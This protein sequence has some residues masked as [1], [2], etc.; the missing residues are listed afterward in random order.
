MSKKSTKTLREQNLEGIPFYIKYSI[1]TLGIVLFYIVFIQIARYILGLLPQSHLWGKVDSAIKLNNYKFLTFELIHILLGFPL[2]L[3]GVLL[4]IK[5]SQVNHHAQD[6]ES[7]KPIRLIKEGVYSKVRHP[8]YAGFILTQ[9]GLWFS[10]CSYYTIFIAVLLVAIFLFNGWREERMI[11]IP[12]FGD[13]YKEYINQVKS[14]FFTKGTLIYFVFIIIFS[15][16]GLA[17]G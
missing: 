14:R 11:L 7:R 17:L 10:L 6:K 12:I 5:T 2:F 16:F 13:G 15:V 8:M 3:Y 4:V 1:I 9:V